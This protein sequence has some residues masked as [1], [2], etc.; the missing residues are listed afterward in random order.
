MDLDT[1]KKMTPSWSLLA[2]RDLEYSA[3]DSACLLFTTPFRS[4]TH[5][6]KKPKHHFL[7]HLAPDIWR[8]GPA[9]PHG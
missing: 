4:T 7:T 3:H 8:F 6:L 9:P 2:A 5:G 1:I